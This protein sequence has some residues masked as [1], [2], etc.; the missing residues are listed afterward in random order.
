MYVYKTDVAVLCLRNRVLFD[1][2][3]RSAALVPHL[4]MATYGV[5]CQRDWHL[6]GAIPVCVN[7]QGQHVILN[8]YTMEPTT[9]AVVCVEMLRLV[10]DELG[11]AKA[12]AWVPIATTG[13]ASSCVEVYL[14]CCF[15]IADT[16]DSHVM[17]EYKEVP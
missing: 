13:P 2:F 5:L 10:L 8:M 9:H 15:Q 14:D 4:E 1:G 6:V 17:V 12:V 11:G 3:A 16:T 7:A